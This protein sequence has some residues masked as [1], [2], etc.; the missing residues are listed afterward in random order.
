MY[1]LVIGLVF[2]NSASGVIQHYHQP[3]LIDDII[4]NMKI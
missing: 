3:Q 4:S 1:W 2:L